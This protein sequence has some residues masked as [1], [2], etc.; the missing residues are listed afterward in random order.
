MT[1]IPVVSNIY[2]CLL[3]LLSF[4]LLFHS[5]LYAV[6]SPPTPV[7]T[8]SEAC[9]NCHPKEYES[10]I[11]YAKKSRSFNSIIRLEKGLTP[12][13]IARCYSCHSTGYGK[14]GGF[15]NPDETPLL[16]NAG[17]EVCHGPGSSHA[18]SLDPSDIKGRLTMEDCKPCHISE[19]IK[20][21]RYKPLIRGGAH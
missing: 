2:S 19:R 1:S 13:E 17:C 14:P 21:F 9:K 16:K 10:F 11:T 4:P 3:V 7:Y 20:A 12:E 15:I 6:E 5:T 18:I 8:G